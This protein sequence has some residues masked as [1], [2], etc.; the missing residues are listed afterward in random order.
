MKNSRRPSVVGRR[1]RVNTEKP[2]KG[3]VLADD[4]EATTDDD[5]VKEQHG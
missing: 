1:L 3:T 5:F 4:R 2:R